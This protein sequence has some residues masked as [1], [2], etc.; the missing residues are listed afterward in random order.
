VT[1]I[2]H[3]RA[4][5]ANMDRMNRILFE[6]HLAGGLVLGGGGLSIPSRKLAPV[7]LRFQITDML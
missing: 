7:A 4:H 3:T 5:S 2:T 1:A 6:P